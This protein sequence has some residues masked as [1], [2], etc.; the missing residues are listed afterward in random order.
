[1]AL[2]LFIGTT[3][4]QHSAFKMKPRLKVEANKKKPGYSQRIFGQ[5]GYPAVHQG[6]MYNDPVVKY[7]L[8]TLL[9]KYD[10]T[11]TG[12]Y[13]NGEKGIYFYNDD[14]QLTSVLQKSW[15]GTWF[16]TWKNDF[17]YNEIGLNDSLIIYEYIDDHW[18]QAFM[19][20]R[21]YNPDSSLQTE[22]YYNWE[23]ARF[24]P[25][26]KMEYQY[27]ANTII[28]NWFSYDNGWIN[29][30][31]VT[32]YLTDGRI[33]SELCQSTYATGQMQNDYK[34]DYLYYANGDLKDRLVSYW[35]ETSWTVPMEKE[36]YTY[37][38][39]NNLDNYTWSTFGEEGWEI[40]EQ[41]LP[42]YNNQYTRED[43]IIPIDPEEEIYFRHM[44]TRRVENY[45]DM[46]DLST[47]I[48]FTTF[49]TPVTVEKA[50][51]ILTLQSS[52]FPNP[53]TDNITIKWD[54]PANSAL[55]TIYNP[56]GSPVPTT[57]ITNNTTIPVTSL[58]PGLYLYT[59]K[60]E[61]GSLG[62]GKFV[63]E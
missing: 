32:Y 58:K 50:K 60:G 46:G 43:L 14:F 31:I 28:E 16:D 5:T 59:L 2:C 55:L 25:S 41:S 22:T 63:V 3:Y 52:A 27:T 23:W 54:G 11:G 12:N 45:Y 19:E 17:S 61:D 34:A 39:E 33:T 1:M 26:Q 29:D 56:T 47:T 51:N 4:A 6:K 62:N 37:D 18:Q 7:R 35:D 38:S 49:Y 10:E 13:I 20:I 30:Y 21:T 40:L 42:E 15:N 9:I 36:S 57:E 53:A 44:L 48:E 8:D 24:V